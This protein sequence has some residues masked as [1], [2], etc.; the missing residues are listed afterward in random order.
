MNQGTTSVSVQSCSEYNPQKVGTAIRKA[1]EE[2][3]NVSKIKRGERVFLKINHLP[4]ASPPERGIVTHPV[5]VEETAKIFLDLGAKVTIGDDVE[6]SGNPYVVSGIAGISKRLGVKVVNLK[7]RGF[8]EVTI[9]AGELLKTVHAAHEVLEADAIVSLPKLKTHSFTLL[10]GALK[11][12]YGVIPLGERIDLHRDYPDA[13]NFSRALVDLYS[14]FRPRLSIAD[15]IVAMEGEG[16]SSGKTKTIGAVLVG[17]DAVAVDAVMAL[18]INVNPQYIYTC[19]I[20]SERDLGIS[21]LKQIK[22]LG[23]GMS[24][25]ISDFLLPASSTQLI[26]KILPSFLIWWVYDQMVRVEP[27]VDGGKCIGCHACIR[28][29]PT[30]AMM[31][32][33]GAVGVD[34]TLCIQ[35]FCCQE[36]CRYGAVI[37]RQKPLAKIIRKIVEIV[38]RR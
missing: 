2:S 8:E 15:A 19:Q 6:S 25:A 29:C 24:L 26:K 20:A 33:D 4:P 12:I 28:V 5:F 14:A 16:P 35:C 13:E 17:E 18:L 11:N 9:E 22:I 10:T 21:D 37:S 31:E 38:V 1:L 34:N 23:D 3:G 30:K 36:A 32:G 27:V 7:E